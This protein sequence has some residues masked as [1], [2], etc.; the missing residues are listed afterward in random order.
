MMD[1]SPWQL[2]RPAPLLGQHTGAVLTELGYAAAQIDALA[3][4]GVI[5]LANAADA[6]DTAASANAAA[7]KR[8]D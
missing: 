8:S 5:I 4:A 1:K 6:A 2:R 7:D 3:A